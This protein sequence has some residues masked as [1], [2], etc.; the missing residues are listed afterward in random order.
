MAMA[1]GGGVLWVLRYEPGGPR[2]A[3][4]NEAAYLP[5]YSWEPG[6]PAILRR[7]IVLFAALFVVVAMLVA[8]W[9]SRLAMPLLIVAVVAAVAVLGYW[10]K[11]QSPVLQAWGDVVVS[12]DP[13]VQRD[14]WLY[15]TS[16][17]AIDS[18]FLWEGLCH[19]VFADAG[20]L[21]RSGMSLRCGADGRP[22]LFAYHLGAGA[23]ICFLART[24]VAGD[25]AGAASDAVT[26]PLRGVVQSMYLARGDALAGQIMPA[27]PANES[28]EVW[29]AALVRRSTGP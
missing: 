3:A 29:P 24:L 17:D 15:Q 28:A 16:P 18:G 7:R 21:E 26:S 6:W 22:V 4:F 12:D 5:T 23:R 14:R 20:Q 13:W 8:L 1:R 10:R 25:Q 9:R 27:G 19:P 2:T 11:W